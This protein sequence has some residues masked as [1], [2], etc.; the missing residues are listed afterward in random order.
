MNPY[1]GEHKVT[2]GGKD[3]ALRPT[4]DALA[5]ME[6]ASGMKLIPLAVAFNARNVGVSEIV[7]VIVEGARGADPDVDGEALASAIVEA[8]V[9]NFVEVALAFLSDALTGGQKG[10]AGAAGRKKATRSAA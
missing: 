6:T 4:Y 7:A 2:V 10:N 8:G 5:A 3:Y 9:L 1:R